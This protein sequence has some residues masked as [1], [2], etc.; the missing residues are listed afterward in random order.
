VGAMAKRK[1]EAEEDRI[2]QL[3]MCF[4]SYPFLP[5]NEGSHWYILGLKK[6]GSSTFHASI[7]PHSLLQTN[8]PTPLPPS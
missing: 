1:R 5:Y 8:H 2:S 4:V 3:Q 7:S 6:M